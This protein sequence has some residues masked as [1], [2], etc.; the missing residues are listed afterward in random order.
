MLCKSIKAY[1][2][3]FVFTWL[4]NCDDLPKSLKALEHNE[5]AGGDKAEN[6][7]SESILEAY[8]DRFDLIRDKKTKLQ[9]IVDLFTLYVADVL[10]S[11]TVSYYRETAA[12]KKLESGGTSRQS[13]NEIRKSVS[14]SD[15]RKDLIDECESRS[16][17][18][19]VDEL[20]MEKSNVS[21]DILSLN[22]TDNSEVFDDGNAEGIQVTKITTQM[23]NSSNE[24]DI[25]EIKIL[26]ELIDEFEKQRVSA[27]NPFYFFCIAK[28]Y[29]EK[30]REVDDE[31]T[32]KLEALLTRSASKCG[33]SKD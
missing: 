1:Y 26:K 30:S 24:S 23:E 20:E 27:P 6:Q 25:A 2:C 15:D 9:K 22:Q 32:S 13:L 10:D 5:L 21:G 12:L 4:V 8:K 17:K 11:G 19:S 3:D 33:I 29:V 28:E 18:L 16:L 14:V 31:L 7:E